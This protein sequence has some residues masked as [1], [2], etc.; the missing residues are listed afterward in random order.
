MK[1][2]VP[3]D[4]DGERLDLIVA[5]LGGLSRAA[6]RELV[7]G[8]A[9]T[10][11]GAVRGGRDRVAAGATVE[12]PPPA[13]PPGL[14]PERVPFEVRYED[15]HLAVI[16]KP[17]GVV[18]HPGAGRSRGTLAAGILA[19]WPRV[20]GVGAEDRW[21]IVH[22]LD[23]DTSGLLLVAL[24]RQAYDRL[25]EAIASRAVSRRYLALVHGAPEAPTGT[26]DAPIG[27]DA[28][29][30]TR[31]RVQASGRHATTHFRVDRVWP[32]FTLLEVT[33]D[34][35]RTH[36]IRVHL[37]SIGLP[38]AG[39]RVY[40]RAS[41]SPRVFLHA[42]RLGFTHPV[43]GAAVDVSSPLPEDLAAVV[44][45]LGPPDADG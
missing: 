32:G 30:P 7:A 39:D 10:V 23:R 16:D 9:V 34:T 8:G 5:R 13:S 1:A 36:Q 43:G 37:A 26:I 14:V 33:L 17:A 28:T 15:E 22:R 25:R 27:R 12:F 44:A 31:M 4:L 18:V 21:G 29:R 42:H 24:D 19:R 40:G 2:A 20:R 3:A 41:G 38:L 45:A 6:A 35:G 11:D